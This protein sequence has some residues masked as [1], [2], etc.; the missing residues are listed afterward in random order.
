MVPNGHLPF[1][2]GQAAVLCLRELQLVQRW[3]C[4]ALPVKQWLKVAVSIADQ[5]VLRVA[6]AF[7]R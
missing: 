4:F 2:R 6:S 1:L 3:I 5:L 7:C